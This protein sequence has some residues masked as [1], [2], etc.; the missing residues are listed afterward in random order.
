MVFLYF[1]LQRSESERVKKGNLVPRVFPLLPWERGWKQGRIL[2]ESRESKPRLK[3][4][5]FYQNPLQMSKKKS[6]CSAI[7][8]CNILQFQNPF[9]ALQINWHAV[10]SSHIVATSQARRN[11]GPSF[12]AEQRKR[13]S[14]I[15]CI[16]LKK[17]SISPPLKISFRAVLEMLLLLTKACLSRCWPGALGL[18]IND[19]FQRRFCSICLVCYTHS[20]SNVCF[21]NDIVLI[22]L[23]N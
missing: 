16:S 10:T 15:I 1:L 23:F 21:V 5:K 14:W 7:P 19:K 18:K 17:R 13:K 3:P 11:M 20:H 8:Q 4:T 6:F 2:I 9:Y 22:F 12:F